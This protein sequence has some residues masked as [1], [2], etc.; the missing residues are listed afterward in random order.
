MERS[1]H[2]HG[3]LIVFVGKTVAPEE[4]LV[5][6]ASD[7]NAHG[8]ELKSVI[9]GDTIRVVYEADVDDDGTYEITDEVEQHVGQGVD[10][11]GYEVS[12]H[13]R[14]QACFKNKSG[15]T[16]DIVV[17]AAMIGGSVS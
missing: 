11:L 16:F 13:G 10:S 7:A 5:V 2:G 17:T 14:T 1:I 8:L 15:A 12:H 3:D 9:H 6:N 4:D